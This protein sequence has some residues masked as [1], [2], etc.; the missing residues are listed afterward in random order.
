MM[1]KTMKK[2]VALTMAGMMAMSISTGAVSVLAAET[3]EY[4][5]GEVAGTT[6]SCIPVSEYEGELDENAPDEG[7]VLDVQ[8][9]NTDAKDYYVFPLFICDL[10]GDAYPG[11]HVA[12]VLMNTGAVYSPDAVLNSPTSLCQDAIRVEAGTSKNVRYYIDF[13]AE[14]YIAVCNTQYTTDDQTAWD[15]AS[16]FDAD[17]GFYLGAASMQVMVYDADV[18]DA[19]LAAEQQQEGS[20]PQQQYQD[21]QYQEG[22]QQENGYTEEQV[23]QFSE[24]GNRMWEDAKDNISEELSEGLGGF[25][26]P[27]TIEQ[28]LELGKSILF[29]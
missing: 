29:E 14:D 23:Q 21:P 10:T 1:K 9:V 25:L 28:G 5:G 7:Y 19:Q 15:N 13:N 16:E 2:M 17:Q 4:V 20:Q 26:S 24:F 27:G 8:F 3:D 6:S 11:E 22:T 18:L 12:T